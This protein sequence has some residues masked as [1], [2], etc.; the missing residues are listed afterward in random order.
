MV[1]FIN[2]L[3]NGKFTRP[4]PL[5]KGLITLNIHTM[6]TLSAVIAFLMILSACSSNQTDPTDGSSG[7]EGQQQEENP[8]DPKFFIY[9]A[10][11]S[12]VN[13]IEDCG[14]KYND[15]ANYQRADYEIFGD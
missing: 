8:T 1:C 2:S 11:H 9:G 6:N 12:Y 10:N 7:Q 4:F 13:E 3:K 15:N 14:G 5:K